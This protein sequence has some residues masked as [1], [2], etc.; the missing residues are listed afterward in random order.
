VVSPNKMSNVTTKLP[1]T[2]KYRFGVDEKRRLQVPAKWRPEDP[3]EFTIIVWPKS[4]C[5]PCLR[6]LPRA[7]MTKVWDEINAMSND[8]PNKGPI[9]R[10]IGSE[11]E[12]LPVD[13][14]GRV[15]LPEEKVQAA[16]IGK[17]VVMVGMLDWIEIWNP[18]RYEKVKAAEASFA[19]EA[20]KMLE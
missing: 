5:G 9:K 16:D 13:K 20:L 7:A 6:V 19:A 10:Y 8:N 3:S 17:E 1:L 15:C 12:Q 11:S 18:D 4:P 2:G 14:A